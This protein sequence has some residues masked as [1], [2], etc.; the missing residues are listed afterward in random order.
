MTT[1]TQAHDSPRIL[2]V[3]GVAGGASAAARARRAN[4]RA[5][6]ILFERDPH[7]SFANCGLPYFIGGGISDRAQLLVAAPDLFRDRFRIVRGS[8]MADA[9]E[10]VVVGAGYIGLEVADQFVHRGLKVTVVELQAQVIPLVDREI[11]EPLNRGSERNG[12]GSSS[13][14][15]SPRSR[16]PTGP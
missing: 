6:I 10:V 5:R 3:G 9:I 13:A 7:V 11:A 2:I 12:V 4:E 16:K 14:A 15:A 8:A 1:R